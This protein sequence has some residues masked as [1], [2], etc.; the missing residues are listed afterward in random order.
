MVIWWIQGV[1]RVC[2]SMSLSDREKSSI[3]GSLILQNDI[4]SVNDSF[5]NIKV[6]DASY[7]THTGTS[8]T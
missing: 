8:S 6:L 4:Q 2:Y 1:M 3:I 5:E 7:V